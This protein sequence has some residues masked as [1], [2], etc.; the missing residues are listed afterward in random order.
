MKSTFAALPV[1]LSLAAGLATGELAANEPVESAPRWTSSRRASE[2]RVLDGAWFAKRQVVVYLVSKGGVPAIRKAATAVMQDRW[3]AD[4]WSTT[5]VIVGDAPSA[6]FFAAA[7]RLALRE[8]TQEMEKAIA[9]G[10]GSAEE[11]E[12]FAEENVFFVHDPDGKVWQEL[13]GTPTADGRPTA[14]VILE[15]GRVTGVVPLA[16]ESSAASPDG[17]AQAAAEVHRLL[18]SEVADSR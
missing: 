1:L 18:S 2:G 10:A 12:K 8:A 3:A 9:E 13:L 15:G 17:P 11:G 7:R 4:D 16:K 5:H 14:V 6:T